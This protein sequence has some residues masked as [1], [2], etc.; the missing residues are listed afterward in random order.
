MKADIQVMLVE[1]HPEYR[2]V[3]D[4]ALADEPDIKLI[5]QVGSSERAISVLKDHS[6]WQTPDL[7]LLDLNLPG[8]S[9][10]ESIAAIFSASPQSKIIILTQSDSEDDVLMA[11]KR[12]ASGYLL[13][14]SSTSQ[15]VDAI[16]AV[17]GGGAV[18]DTHVAKYILNNLQAWL[19]KEDQGETLSHRELE[20]LTLL[21]EGLSKKQISEKLAISAATVATYIRRVYEK[22]QVQNAP[23]A[24]AKAYRIGI[25][26]RDSP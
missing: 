1:D 5:N 19:P 23:S 11:I 9:G 17:A 16:R 2:E 20:I 3:I 13:K 6:Q 18:L 22:L 12:G 15:I 10:L 8:T 24:I 7:I 25:F 4:L 26:R 21:G 14:S